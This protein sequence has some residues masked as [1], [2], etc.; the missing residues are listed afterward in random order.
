MGRKKISIYIKKEHVHG[1]FVNPIFRNFA[2]NDDVKSFFGL[3][4]RV[5]WAGAELNGIDTWECHI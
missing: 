3:W 1:T 4:G 2:C 5:G